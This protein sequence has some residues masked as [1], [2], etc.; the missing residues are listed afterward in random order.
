MVDPAPGRLNVT[1]V[2]QLGEPM[3]L[4]GESGHH[5]AGGAELVGVGDARVLHHGA[6]GPAM[7]D[8][9]ASLLGDGA[10]QRDAQAQV[11]V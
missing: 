7:L 10:A 1:L 2:G 6:Q 11:V 3:T 8:R 4:D 5:G 9:V